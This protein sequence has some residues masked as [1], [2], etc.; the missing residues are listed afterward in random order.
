[1]N[2]LR[3]LRH[4]HS[5]HVDLGLRDDKG[6]K[7]GARVDVLQADVLAAAIAAFSLP[8]LADVPVGTVVGYARVHVTRDGRIF[9][10]TPEARFVGSIDAADAAARL[11][12]E[13]DRRLAAITKRYTHMTKPK[14]ASTR[15]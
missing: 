7:I 11:K 3:N 6:R 5:W 8:E 15:K 14:K 2:G 13:V 1:M 9:G 4:V 10:A 12:A